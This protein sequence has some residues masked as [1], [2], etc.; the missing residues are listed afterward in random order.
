[1]I[2]SEPHQDGYLIRYFQEDTYGFIEMFNCPK[3][4]ETVPWI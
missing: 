2:Y 4:K 1:M 3:K